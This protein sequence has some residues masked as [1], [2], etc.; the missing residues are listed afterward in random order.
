MNSCNQRGHNNYKNIILKEPNEN[1]QRAHL[2]PRAPLWTTLCY[3]LQV[4]TIIEDIIESNMNWEYR[5]ASQVD[6]WLRC[7]ALTPRPS[8]QSLLARRAPVPASSRRLTRRARGSSATWLET[9]GVSNAIIRPD[10]R[11]LVVRHTPN[12]APLLT[13]RRWRR[14]L[15]IASSRNP[16]RFLFGIQFLIWSHDKFVASHIVVCHQS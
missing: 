1:P 3:T 16:L 10:A 7:L 15:W 14:A 13:T 4:V 11:V 8:A 6:Y 12:P 5:W 9:R 2:G